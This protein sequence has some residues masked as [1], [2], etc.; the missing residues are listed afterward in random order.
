MFRE[1]ERWCG[2]DTPC[3]SCVPHF[4]PVCEPMCRQST[5]RSINTQVLPGK[6]SE[7]LAGVWEMESVAK[8]QSTAHS[9]LDSQGSASAVVSRR[10]SGLP[11]IHVWFKYNLP[12]GRIL[13]SHSP[14]SPCLHT[15]IQFH[16]ANNSRSICL[17]AAAGDGDKAANLAMWNLVFR[18]W[19]RPSS[20]GGHFCLIALLRGWL[21][22]GPQGTRL[23]GKLKACPE[24][25]QH[26]EGWA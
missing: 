21:R 7:K 12:N 13:A 5:A 20:P 8:L 18:C 2:G 6:H 4:D 3:R 24:T 23:A 11:R 15:K 16:K 25:G 22:V 9:F 14:A 17:D 19:F 10:Y 26:R 1:T